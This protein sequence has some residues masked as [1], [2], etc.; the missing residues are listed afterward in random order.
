[1]LDYELG[2]LPPAQQEHQ[3]LIRAFES[4]LR[5]AGLL[6]VSRYM[7]LA[8]TAHALGSLVTGDDPETSVVDADGRVHGMQGLYVADGSVLPRSS[9]VNPALTIY[10]WG[11]RLGD[12]LT[13]GALR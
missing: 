10:A 13:N 8:G 1:M 7:G 11:L 5:K 6:G 9:R 2:R 12:Y 3:G 4:A